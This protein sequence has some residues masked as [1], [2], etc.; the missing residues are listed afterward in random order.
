[1]TT[2]ARRHPAERTPAAAA[3]PT[4]GSRT[5]ALPGL[6]NVRD[7]A[8]L[9]RPDGA[10]LRS[11]VL[12]RGPAPSPLTAPALDDLGIRTV[13]DLR[14]AFE[15]GIEDGP[16]GMRA[17]LLRRPVGGNMSRIRGVRR[18]PPSA[19]LFNYRS[20]LTL[21]A[22]VAV[23]I[24]GLLAEP[25]QDPVYVCCTVG[26][27]RT[28]VVSAL[29]LRGLGVRLAAVA[30]DYSLTGRAY[31]ALGPQDPRPQWSYEGSLEELQIRTASPAWTMRSLITGIEDEHESVAR[32]L[33]RQHGLSPK[34]RLRA[35]RRVFEHH[36]PRRERHDAD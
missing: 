4:R 22:P 8:G 5:V 6:P 1:M 14:T 12:Y 15:Q 24:I 26:K 29:T 27:D 16:A 10:R 34:T 30:G 36:A 21:A 11:G 35:V 32:Y 31:R 23:E 28:G 7:S 25:D 18:P 33:E 17:R 13:V 2:G 9:P 20:M 19:Y 3:R